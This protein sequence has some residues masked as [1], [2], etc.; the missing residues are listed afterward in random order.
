MP[1]YTARE[2]YRFARMAGFSPDQSATMTA[3]A[4]A[5]SGGQSSAH[6]PR[7][8]DS[9]GLW[10]INVAA[11]RDLAGTDLY[12]PVENAKAAFRI[13]RSGQDV[14]PWTTTH[15]GSSA[16]YLQHR[17]EA[18]AAAR[19]AGD[20]GDVGVWTGTPGY[21]SPLSAG[22]GGG[23][24]AV[25]SLAAGAPAGAGSPTLADDFV[26]KAM[27]QTGD[28]YV[29]G[30]EADLDDADP[31]VFDCSEL[32]QW[33]A[34][35]VG[36]DLPDGSWLQY[37]ALEKQ[38]GSMTVEQALK[39]KG[40]LLFSFSESPSGAGRPSSAHVAISLGDGRTIEARGTK[41]GV[42]SWEANTD[43]FNYAAVVPQL[44]G[45][46]TG[47]GADTGVAKTAL[48]ATPQDFGPAVDN[49]S[50]GL[51]DGR[52]LAL[53][54]DARNPDSD[55][56][57][58]S[59][60]YEVARLG[61]SAS[62]ADTDGDRMGDAFELAA[63]SDPNDPD[64]DHDGRL[65][66]VAG[67]A[68]GDADGIDDEL[69]RLLGSDAQSLDSDADGF[70]DGLEYGAYFDPADPFSNPVDGTGVGASA[71]PGSPLGG[72]PMGGSPRGTS[73]LGGSPGTGLTRSG[74]SGRDAT[75]PD[76]DPLGDLG[77]T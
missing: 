11:H 72:S 2:I 58:L 32:T 30:A 66:G 5:E 48:A 14:S 23:G 37:Q 75:D 25:S 44:S 8:E 24:G 12:D 31:T 49:D 47:I 40:A 67:G 21:G 39:T 57:G 19:A 27:A 15:G 42:G 52:E 68:D 63:G 18:E 3:I 1:V 59:D 28:R 62:K 38:G 13:S 17:M 41:Y 4:L 29:F 33:A 53:G 10:Q 45:P 70:A 50:D 61:T 6:N 77:G 69:E 64:S 26:D 60:G 56:D 9:R 34:K 7:G 43:R 55:A 74:L 65:D 35:Q 76:P 22:G 46:G 36:V 73:A 51:V 71:T 20:G 16:K 54:I